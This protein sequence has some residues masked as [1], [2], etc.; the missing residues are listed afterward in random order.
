[1]MYFILFQRHAAHLQLAWAVRDGTGPLLHPPPCQEEVGC[2]DG[3]IRCAVAPGGGAAKFRG[4]GWRGLAVAGE[5]LDQCFKLVERNL[6]IDDANKYPTQK[7][8]IDP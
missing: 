5:G 8:K 2:R 6:V 7:K 1:M 4:A 3:A